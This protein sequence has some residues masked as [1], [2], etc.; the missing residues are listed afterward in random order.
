MNVVVPTLWK[1]E[2]G[3]WYLY[4]DPNK[5][6]NPGG[7]ATQLPPPATGASGT[8]TTP[9][10]PAL[11]AMP[12]DLP[13]DAGFVLGKVQMD[14][15][16]VRISAGGTQKVTIANGST[17]TISLEYGYPLGGIQAKLDRTEVNRGEKA[18]LTLTA[19]KEPTGGTYYV[20][21]MPTGESLVINVVVQ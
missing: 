7:A 15:S 5:I 14:K 18:V 17:G 1:V 6:R 10:T 21:V 20:R 11:P 3:N 9:A 16:N 12:K 4:E 13:K 8:P 19:G 2:N